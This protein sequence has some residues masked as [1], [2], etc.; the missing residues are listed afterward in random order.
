VSTG[1]EV[2]NTISGTLGR[3]SSTPMTPIDSQDMSSLGPRSSLGLDG[4][5]VE[6]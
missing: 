3:Q 6:L 5:V 4:T 2:R 1:D